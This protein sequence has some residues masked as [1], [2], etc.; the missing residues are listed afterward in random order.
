MVEWIGVA[1]VKRELLLEG[2]GAESGTGVRNGGGE[3]VVGER[4]VRLYLD[5]R[6]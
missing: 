2:E 1:V 6:G 5:G 4:G 3:M